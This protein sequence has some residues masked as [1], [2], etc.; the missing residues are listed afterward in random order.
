MFQSLK[1]STRHFFRTVDRPNMGYS[2][3]TDRSRE[4]GSPDPT[5][6]PLQWLVQYGLYV[7]TALLGVIVG[8][9]LVSLVFFLLGALL[10][11]PTGPPPENGQ[12][13]GTP[14]INVGEWLVNAGLLVGLGLAVVLV[15]HA[16]AEVVSLRRGDHSVALDQPRGIAYAAVRVVESG[17]ALTLVGIWGVGFLLSTAGLVGSEPPGTVQFAMLACGLAMPASLVG[18]ALGRA[19]GAVVDDW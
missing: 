12:T 9:V 4:E 5:D 19:G 1:E 17:S 8:L 2:Q 3:G 15:V 11:F 18:H 7:E 16:V 6:E 14:I 10:S 13:P